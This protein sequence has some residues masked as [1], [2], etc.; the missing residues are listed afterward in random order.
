[1]RL[2]RRIRS[3]SAAAAVGVVLLAPA[4][5]A[6]GATLSYTGSIQMAQGT[7]YF[8][9]TVRGLFFV[10]GFYLNTGAFNLSASVP[11]VYQ[12]SP[13]VS[14]SGIGVLP[15][16]GS[17][18]PV[19]GSLPG[20]RPGSN[21]IVLPE[22]ETV[23]YNRFGLADPFFRMGFRLWKESRFAP[24]VEISAHAK[25]PVATFESGFGTG[26]WDYG[27]GVS[28]SKRL[29][30]VFLLADIGYWVLGDLPELE[31]ND[32]WSYIASLGIP[33]SGGKAAL[34]FSYSGFTKII[35]GV[36][37]PSSLGLG[38]SFRVGRRSSLLVNG[39]LGLSESSA[40]FSASL[41]WS[42][43]L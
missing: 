27:A 23:D 12:N 38:I 1:M 5:S 13:Y 20:R 3:A 39:S 33:L 17:Q 25:V 15:T 19:V 6:A 2:L 8:D 22:P 42:I 34:T 21:P 28:L 9:Q 16:G 4:A 14:Y 43:G 31:L 11:V 24:S 18:S 7:Y 26:Q 41:G 32:P 36:E 40:D 10:N 37:P 29:G 30:G 35:S